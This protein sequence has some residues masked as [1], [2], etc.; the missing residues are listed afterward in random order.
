M[1]FDQQLE[2]SSNYFCLQLVKP[3]FYGDITLHATLLSYP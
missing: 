1:D 3:M 2:E